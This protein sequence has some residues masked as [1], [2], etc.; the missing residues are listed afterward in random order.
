MNFT[1]TKPCSEN[2]DKMKPVSGGRF[3]DHCSK[4]VHDL[5]KGEAFPAEEGF[6]GRINMQVPKQVSFK[7]FLFKQS[8]VRYFALM[9]VLLFANKVKAQLNKIQVNNLTVSKESDL[10]FDLLVEVTGKLENEKTKMAIADAFVTLYD[11]QRNVLHVARTDSAGRFAFAVLQRR[12]ADSLFTLKAEYIGL[13][14]VELTDI[15]V[16]KKKLELFMKMA[17]RTTYY[18]TTTVGMMVRTVTTATSGTM[19]NDY[20]HTPNKDLKA[21]VELMTNAPMMRSM[22]NGHRKYE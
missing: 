16:T 8:P 20:R 9:F 11:S 21:I 19:A 10:E 22:D 12:I 18:T 17:E 6:C 7:K 1:I 5:T 4:K 13:E 14:T 2:W 15:P 3:C